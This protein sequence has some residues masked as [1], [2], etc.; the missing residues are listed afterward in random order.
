MHRG[1]GYLQHCR[2]FLP[3]RHDGAEPA[4]HPL[5][6]LRISNGKLAA[7]FEGQMMF[8]RWLDPPGRPR[9]PTHCGFLG[10][11][12]TCPDCIASRAA[13]PYSI[14]S[15]TKQ[16]C[17]SALDMPG[18]RFRISRVIMPSSS[19]VSSPPRAMMRAP[20]SVRIWGSST[21]IVRHLRCARYPF[22]HTPQ[23]EKQNIE[24]GENIVHA[25]NSSV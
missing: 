1:L 16:A 17:R 14:R 13:G 8:F 7:G 12:C 19:I 9:L 25:G 4:E 2:A 11:N 18:A 5:G 22:D 10:S 15:A 6:A 21:A 20:F 3:S 23:D 24:E